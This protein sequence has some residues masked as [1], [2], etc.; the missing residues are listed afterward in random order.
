MST[1]ID[2]PPKPV[3]QAETD[4]RL[5]AYLDSWRS[6]LTCTKRADRPTAEAAIEGLYRNIG[7][8]RPR[9]LWVASPLVGALAYQS[10]G[11]EHRALT[12]PYAKG[13]IGNGA[14]R[15]QEQLRIAPPVVRE[16]PSYNAPQRQSAPSAPRQSAPRQNAPSAPR[17]SSPG[18]GGGNHGNPGGNHSGG[19]H[20]GGRNR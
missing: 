16:R 13:D 19:N 6:S 11:T 1:L 18:N 12:S 4:E 15:Q 3:G 10:V 2:L 17:Q 7:L 14:N 20:G 5:S 9:I 8:E